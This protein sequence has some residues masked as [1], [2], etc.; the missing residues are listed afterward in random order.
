ML[1]CIVRG[2]DIQLKPEEIVRQLY[3]ARLLHEYGYPKNRLVIEYPV[4]FGLEDKRADLVI[5]DK[6]RPD[7]AYT[8]IELKKPKLREGKSQLR[9]YCNATGASIGVWTN[10][11]QIS[12]YNRKDPNYFEDITDI[13]QAG[14]SLADILKEKFIL[15]DLIIRDKVA[16]NR[17]SLKDII[18]EMED[19]VLANAGVD[20]FEEVFKLIFT[21]LYDEFRSQLDKNV[22]NHLI[23][24]TTDTAVHEAKSGYIATP[25]SFGGQGYDALKAAVTRIAGTGFRLMEFR[26][27][28]QTDTELKNKIQDL[29][30]RAIGQWPGVFPE[31]PPLNSL[32]V[33]WPSACP[34]YRMSRCSTPICW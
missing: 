32:T 33:T 19:E 13:P 15:R 4:N 20:V 28:G 3:A 31:G 24:Q 1:N 18:L 25:G 2:K 6:D 12:H 7:A 17:K 16:N 27:T 5:L 26:N 14:Q 23:R 10:G 21:K 30:R 8:I 34:A 9:P 22:I 11:E 29:F